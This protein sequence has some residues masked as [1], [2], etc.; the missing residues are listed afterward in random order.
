[1][2][3]MGARNWALGAKPNSGR[4]FAIKYQDR[5]LFGTDG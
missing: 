5:I 4:K 3:E 2:V 1:M